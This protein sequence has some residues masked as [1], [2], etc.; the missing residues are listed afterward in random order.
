M[1]GV[2]NIVTR[3][4]KEDGIKTGINLG[5][6]SYNSLMTEVTNRIKKGRFSSMVTAS[7]NRTD[8]HRKK[9]PA[10]P[11]L[12]QHLQLV[13]TFISKIEY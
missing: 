11:C 2:I 3:K 6:G 12:K 1:G 9:I 4:Q 7:Y 5:Y 13:F 10:T 8:G